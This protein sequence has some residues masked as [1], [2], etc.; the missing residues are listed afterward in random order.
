MNIKQKNLYHL[1]MVFREVVKQGSFTA[2]GNKLALTKS[3]ISQHV[4]QLEQHLGV[5]LLIRSTRSL[6]L[7]S[8]GH[9]LLERSDELNTLLDITIDEI[10]N[11]KQQP[12]GRLSIT[13]PQAL[14]LPIV[15]PALKRFSK[16]FPQVQPKLIVDDRNI[17]IIKEGIDIAIRVGDLQDSELK[18][19]KIGE[20]QEILVASTSYLS[21][22]EKA[23][24][25][26]NIDD[27]PFIAT[28]WQTTNFTHFF[29]DNKEAEFE[30]FL[31]PTFEVNSANI[32]LELVSLGLGIA[33]LPDIFVKQHINE[34][35]IQAVLGQLT[36]KKDNIYYVHAYKEKVPLKVKWLIE[37]LKENMKN[38]QKL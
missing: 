14:A 26:D 27:H 28:S 16:K 3:A 24:T 12:T 17:D 2:A 8:V 29:K 1:L 36:G 13:V 20:H 5:Q 32:A 18:A 4:T 37:F 25:L 11:I 9:K 15:L 33:L 6:S 34:G 38:H 23:V 10:N 19:S 22:L 31:K 21:A 30:V 35:K 7:T